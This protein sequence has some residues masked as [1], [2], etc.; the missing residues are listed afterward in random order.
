MATQTLTQQNF[1]E[2]VTTNDVVLVDFWAS[3]CG[4]CRSFAPTFEASAEA[5]PDV[6]HGKVDTEAQQ[7]LA[8]AA[9]IRSIPTI[10]A[11]REGVLV[12]AQPGALAPEA[13]AELIGQVKALDM[14][15]V[16]KQLAEQQ[17]QAAPDEA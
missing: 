1:D 5:N 6:V 7:E 16:R 2:V 3:W 10:M 14:E 11:F 4:P 12:F 15:H 9:N 8:Q 13:L 17:A